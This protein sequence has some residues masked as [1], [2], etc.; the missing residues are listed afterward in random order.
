MARKAILIEASEVPRQT[1]LPG[2][3]EDVINLSRFLRSMAGGEWHSSEIDVLANPSVA[4]VLATIAAARSADYAFVSFSGH[5]RHVVGKD[6]DETR[7]L[8]RDGELSAFQLNTGSDRVT[9]IIDAC[10]H[11]SELIGEQRSLQANAGQLSYNLQS[12]RALFD[13]ELR[14]CERGAIYMYGCDLNE[15]A[16]ENSK[17]GLFTRSLIG[18]GDDWFAGPHTKSSDVL[19]IQ[20]AFA[21]AAVITTRR[22]PQ[23]HPQYQP[24]R[25]LHH[26]PFAVKRT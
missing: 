2:A 7:I 1:P 21:G 22:A 6:I 9:V 16:N 23:Q 26:F 14:L 24:G 12:T 8:L 20:Q 11:V 4:T 15:G 10:R 5:G 3:K 19:S 18:V 25:R 13:S 17:G